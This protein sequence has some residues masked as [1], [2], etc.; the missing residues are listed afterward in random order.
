[1]NFSDS[2]IVA[3]ILSESGY[4]TTRNIE[5]ADAVFLN[6]CSIRDK[7][8]KTV[9]Q[10]ISTFKLVEN[11]KLFWNNFFNLNSSPNQRSKN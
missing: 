3:S 7:A 9:R 8:E 2:E 11:F 4:Q 10:R 5:E 6:T 1:M